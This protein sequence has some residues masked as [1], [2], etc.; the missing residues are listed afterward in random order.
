MKIYFVRHGESVQS[1]KVYQ[2]PDT[3]LSELGTQ[4]AQNVAERLK[5]LPIDL[6]LTSTFD[7]SVQ[8]TQ[9]ITNMIDLP[10]IK[11][12][13]IIE[14]RMPTLFVGKPVNDP[15]VEAIHQK[16]R[17]HFYEPDWHHADEE[18]FPD[19]LSRAKKALE[20]IISQNKET[21]VV[22]THGYFLSVLIFDIILGDY[23]SSKYFKPFRKHTEFS[24]GGVTVCEYKDDEWKVLSMNG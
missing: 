15:D 24:N 8:T 4:Q 20:F 19:L 12:N 10:V 14:R 17:D 22:V 1:D 2:S 11:S 6:I 5:D 3:T 7:R 9:E 13:L 23:E 18:N 16:L 21:I